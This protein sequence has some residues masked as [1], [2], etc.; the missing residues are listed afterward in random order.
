MTLRDLECLI[1]I[2]K[3]GSISRAAD[4]LAVAQPALSRRMA[5]LENEI[6]GPL[7]TRRARGIELT[8][9]GRALVEDSTRI[10]RDV[11]DARRRAQAVAAGEAGVLTIA[12]IGSSANLPM[13]SQAIRD[14]RR[15]RPNMHLILDRQRSDAMVVA[16]RQGRIDIG[17]GYLRADDAGLEHLAIQQERYILAMPEGHRLASAPVSLADLAGEPLV[18]YPPEIGGRA[19]DEVAAAFAARSIAFNVVQEGESEETLLELV[20]VGIGSAIL[21]ASVILR[22]DLHHIAVQPIRD[23]NLIQSLALFWRPCPPPQVTDFVAIMEPL[24][25]RHRNELQAR[26]L[27]DIVR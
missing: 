23:L 7:F 4:Q 12:F 3:A 14:Y 19:H 25:T 6:G 10:L 8:P 2:A 13:L 20:S 11:V 18:W 17:I 9:A 22:R 1:A 27:G 21:S 26:D 5:F 24:V 16:A 15:T